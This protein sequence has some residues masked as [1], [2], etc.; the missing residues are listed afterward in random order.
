M[1]NTD[2]FIFG[3]VFETF[4]TFSSN[5]ELKNVFQLIE[6]GVEKC[7]A[8]C[9]YFSL[10]GGGGPSNKYTEKGTFVTTETTHC[11]FQKQ[12]YIDVLFEEHQASKA[13]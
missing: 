10:C 1:E 9:S 3:N 2:N 13:S 11:R 5:R 4:E 12:L 8:E 7:K 6:K